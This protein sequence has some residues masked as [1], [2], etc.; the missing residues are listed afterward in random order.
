MKHLQILLLFSFFSINSFAQCNVDSWFME[1]K[2]KVY[3]CQAEKLY[4][5]YDFENGVQVVY[6]QLSI[7]Q[8]PLDKTK[9]QFII[10]IDV[11]ATGSKT[12]VIPRTLSILYDDDKSLLLKG[13]ERLENPRMVGKIK[14]QKGVFVIKAEEFKK[15]MELGIDE[16][17]VMDNRTDEAILCE[18][19]NYLFKEQSNCLVKAINK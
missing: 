13:A 12:H 2:T 5:N 11:G 1:D 16:I 18:P 6:G 8:S 10:F 17:Y 3:L 7:L 15:I 19:F 14:M 9:M 4:S